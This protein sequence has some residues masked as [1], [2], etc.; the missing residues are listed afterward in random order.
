MRRVLLVLGLLGMFSP[1]AT[2]VQADSFTFTDFSS[3]AG[4]DLNGTAVQSGAAI[5]LTDASQFGAAA[6]FFTLSQF[7]VSSGFTTS[8]TFQID[9]GTTI[10]G[11]P[12]D[13]IAFVIQDVGSGALGGA[14]GDAT[15]LGYGGIPKSLAVEFDTYEFNA[16]DL[17]GDS[18]GVQSCGVLANSATSLACNYGAVLVPVLGLHTVNIT[19]VPG[20]LAIAVDGV[21]KLVSA[22]DI[23]TLLSLADGKAYLGFSGSTGGATETARILSW[24]Y[25]AIPEPGTLATV[26]TGLLLLTLLRRRG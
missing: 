26:G 12:A 19:Y 1:A 2:V 8:F 9:G 20:S 7:S 6:S 13:G 23:A 15:G 17:A 11:S 22:L 21:P 5:R 4:L 18:V 24:S 14:G 16:N 10:F 25:A 3:T